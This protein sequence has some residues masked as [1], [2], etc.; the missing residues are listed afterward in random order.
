[1]HIQKHTCPDI[2][3]HTQI[4]IPVSHF[5]LF[6]SFGIYAKATDFIFGT[7]QTYTDTDT[8]THIDKHMYRH[9]QRQTH[10]HT[11][12]DVSRHTLRQ[13]DT[14]THTEMCM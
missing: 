9:T 8:C 6:G 13:I 11:H 2:H 5:A 4:P 3:R 7:P 14:Y 10:S 1:M 12:T